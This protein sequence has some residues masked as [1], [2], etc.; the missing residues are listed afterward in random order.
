VLLVEDDEGVRALGRRI[1]ERYGYTVLE[2]RDGHDALRIAGQYPQRIDVL[3]TDMVM[4]ELSGREVYQ[5]LSP[6]RPGLRVLY[7][8]GYT[9]D[10]IVRR[11]L[12]EATAAFLQKPFT[13]MHLAG[14]VRAVLD[15]RE[16]S[17]EPAA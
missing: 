11:G 13:A 16:V 15:G 10:D 14:A 3:V 2:A 1:L 9:D 4:P 5:R 17:A 8:S 6:A 7:V 12:I